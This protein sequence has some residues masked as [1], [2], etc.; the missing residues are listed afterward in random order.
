[1][2]FRI[3]P[4]IPIQPLSKR[5]ADDPREAYPF[6]LMQVGDSF[7]APDVRVRNSA[8]HWGIRN[9]REFATRALGNGTYRCWRIK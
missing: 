1:M 5:R 9:R 7:V 8:S 6:D 3:E 4:G 2:P